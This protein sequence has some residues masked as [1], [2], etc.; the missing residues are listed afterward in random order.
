[1]NNIDH[2]HPSI[3]GPHY[4][5][6]LHTIS[7][8]YPK[9]PSKSIKKKYY[10]LMTNFSM[11]IPN[12]E[13]STFFDELLNQYPISPYL[14]SRNAFVKWVHFIHNK[15]NQ[16]LERPIITISEFYIQY[17]NK[18]K[19]PTK[20]KIVNNKFWKKIKYVILIAGLILVTYYFHDK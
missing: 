18:Y 8:N 17:Y 19:N 6:F 20:M 5:V 13:I 4:W 2:F 7:L 9:N 14:D 16:K 12:S 11:F 1:M 15:V 3:W 10:D